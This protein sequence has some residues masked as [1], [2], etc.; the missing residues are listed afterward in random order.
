MA[1]AQTDVKKP[2]YA[3][4]SS[5]MAFGTTTNGMPVFTSVV[6]KTFEKAPSPPPN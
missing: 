1:E 3:A 2:Q 4:S 5:P 6:E